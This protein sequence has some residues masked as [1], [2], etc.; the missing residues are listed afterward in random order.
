[1]GLLWCEG[2]SAWGG[3]CVVDAGCR[4]D[5]WLCGCCWLFASGVLVERVIVMAECGH[6]D[7]MMNSVRN[8]EWLVMVAAVGQHEWVS[9]M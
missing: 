4:V 1:M 9:A 7:H 6:G 3:G 8:A 5:W 2:S